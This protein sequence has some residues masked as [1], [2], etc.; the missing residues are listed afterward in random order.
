MPLT[1]S[2]VQ[3]D[4][5]YEMVVDHLTPIGDVWICVGRCEYA[6]AKRLGRE[7]AEELRLLEDLGWAE[8]I[9]REAVSLS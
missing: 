5:I 9:D 2:H 1:I 7:F 8:T 6:D 3:R 4:A